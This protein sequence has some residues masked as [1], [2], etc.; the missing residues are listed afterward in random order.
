MEE[1]VLRDVRARGLGVNE[2]SF[3]ADRDVKGSEAMRASTGTG[4]RIAVGPPFGERMIAYRE[5]HVSA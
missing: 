1:V 2:P 5:P 4:D 3:A